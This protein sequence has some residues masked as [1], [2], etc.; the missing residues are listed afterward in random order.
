M[1]VLILIFAGL[2]GV[3]ALLAG[4]AIWTPRAT[5]VRATAVALTAAF[6]PLAY[7]SLNEVLSRPKPVAHEWF[8][9]NVA[10][11]TVL[12]MSINEGKAIY[13][14]LALDHSLEPRSYVLP[15]R[16]QLADELQKLIAEALEEDATV[17]IANPFGRKA[18][19]DLGEL[20][21]HI[22]P[23]PALPQKKPPTPAR[24]TDP[25]ERQI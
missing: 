18:F 12:G 2:L 3:A 14:W 4:I 5:A 16:A 6:A 13:L 8:R 9:S 24:A 7:L 23:P 10:E 17:K 15:W 1:E 11:A 19:E 21:A 25:R 20:N 22:V